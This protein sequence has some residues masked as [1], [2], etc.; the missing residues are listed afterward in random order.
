DIDNFIDYISLQVITSNKS[1]RH[2]R[3]LWRPRTPAGKFQYLLF[4]QDYGYSLLD[5]NNLKDIVQQDSLFSHLIENEGFK[6]KF[7]QNLAA[8]SQTSFDPD[9]VIHYIDS[10]EAKIEGQINRHLDK[11]GGTWPGMITDKA[12]WRNKV[13]VM[14]DFARNH[15]AKI[16]KFTKNQFGIA[17]M[18]SLDFL[19]N[20]THSGEI[21]IENHSITKDAFSGDFFKG[22]PMTISAR[23]ET[24]YKFVSWSGISNAN[25][26][27]IIPEKSNWKYYDQG[28]RDGVSWT[29][30]GFDDSSWADGDGILG[31]GN[32][33][34]TEIGYGGDASNKYVTAY[35]R[36]S[37]N[38][39]D[40]GDYG[41]LLI[42]LL[43]DDGAVVYLNGTE[44]VRSNMPTGSILFNTLASS[45]ISGSDE[46]SYTQFSVSNSNLLSGDNVIAVEVHQVSQVSSDI[47]F[48]LQLDAE[49][50][51][52]VQDNPY[53]FTP[54]SDL[55]I[56]ANFAKAT[57]SE[58]VISE[59]AYNIGQEFG[60]DQAY[61]FEI[62]N[63]SES[64]IDLGGYIVQ[65]D[66]GFVFP[67]NIVLG[68]NER[69]VLCKDASNFGAVSAMVFAWTSGNLNASGGSIILKNPAGDIADQVNYGI[70]GDWP[71]ASELGGCSIELKKLTSDNND[72]AAW[73]SSLSP[74]GTPGLIN[75][76]YYSSIKINEFAA[77]AS[78]RGYLSGS[79]WVELY[80]AGDEDVDL[81]GL[82]M[83]DN[84]T[85]PFKWQFRFGFPESTVIKHGE[86]IVVTADGKPVK[87]V[88]HCG[89]KLSSEHGTVA[90]KHGF[91]GWV[92]TIDNVDYGIQGS[93]ESYGRFPDGI[94]HWVRLK[95]TSPLA[96]NQ[97]VSKYIT[98]P[99][100]IAS[101]DMMPIF[102]RVLND[103]GSVD[104]TFE[105][106]KTITAT[107]NAVL[108][109]S[110]IPFKKG[111]GYLL[112]KVTAANSFSFQIQDLNDFS[113]VKVS[114]HIPRVY[115]QSAYNADLTLPG[116][117]D[118]VIEDKLDIGQ[119]GSLT[120]ERGARI[121][122]G[123]KTN[124][125]SSG[126]IKINGSPNQPVVFMPLD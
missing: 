92:S 120:I 43:V 76:V 7:I 80:N 110:I 96:P 39:T 9:R 3:R 68:A 34:D 23:P 49:M 22:I 125:W 35:F 6:D 74:G 36:H 64:S 40:P 98:N 61:Y 38:I 124:L 4:D 10:L 18:A 118:Y 33:N 117:V 5:V 65:G 99:Y 32:N 90:I 121:L 79:D 8:L 26:L 48:D 54:V 72:G 63:I 45:K 109:R 56:S 21:L 1:W 91:S 86:Y 116:G 71:N 58:T 126:R 111:V 20:S 93:G 82:Y 37:F 83:T 44:L 55:S 70:S 69:M 19:V 101:G 46:T 15:Q 113:Y 14:R 95:E 108:S 107:N 2:N 77:S 85:Y 94:D 119:Y 17:G 59:I 100:M 78:D 62:T 97:P 27:T 53:T 114:D 13:E 47:S 103:D 12:D 11:W 41:Q 84:G 31:Y 50:G 88:L 66:V 51:E 81:S 102:V 24:G 52:L 42:S 104:M 73:C 60:G 115:L 106:D 28:S 123:D 57:N 67:A 25:E 16:E 105:G 29:D 112:T 75:S 122:I 89:F 30:P 87:G